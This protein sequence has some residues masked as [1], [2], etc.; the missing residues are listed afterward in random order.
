MAVLDS[1]GRLVSQAGDSLWS[2]FCRALVE[3]GV[4]TVQ[5]VA[6]RSPDAI[7]SAN[8]HGRI[9]KHLGLTAIPRERRFLFLAEPDVVHPST[10]RP[11][12]LA[13]YG[14]IYSPSPLR[15]PTKDLRVCMMMNSARDVDWLQVD[16]QVPGACM[17]IGN[18]TSFV[19]GQRYSLRREIVV[20]CE[21]DE[22][23][24]DLYGAGWDRRQVRHILRAITRCLGSGAQVD[25]RAL[26]FQAARNRNL[27][28]VPDKG[29]TASQ[30]RVAVVV[31]N[32]P[33]YVSEKLF[34]AV[35]SGCVALFVGPPLATF[36]LEGAAIECVADAKEVVA[37]IARLLTLE[38]SEIEKIRRR[39]VRSVAAA[40]EVHERFAAVRVLARS[41]GE[42]LRS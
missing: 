42:E 29:R 20:V 34:D 5:D 30:Y 32:C 18:K 6:T 7:F 35:D 37:E 19:R 4:E 9:L 13:S 41:V 23:P 36:G 21:R 12:V 14:Y 24:L 28:A 16:D 10:Y 31:E 8:H 15:L 17:I 27:G 40:R 39:Q 2:H 25:L 11:R 38:N 26:R 3:T 22:V 1:Q 33:D